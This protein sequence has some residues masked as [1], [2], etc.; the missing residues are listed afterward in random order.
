MDDDAA[1]TYAAA[2]DLFWPGRGLEFLP[3]DIGKHSFKKW[4][5]ELALVAGGPPCQPFSLGGLRA[6][7]TDT[8]DGLP[9]FV[10][11]VR[12]TQPEAFLLENVPGLVRGLMRHHFDQLIMDLEALKYR[13]DWRVLKAADFGVPQRR[14]RLM[15]VGVRGRNRFE[16]PEP[17]HGTPA[18]PHVTAGTLVDAHRIIGAPNLSPVTYA[19]APDLRPSPWDGHVWNGGGRPINPAGLAPTMLASMGGNKTPWLDGGNIV[20]NYHAHLLAGGR[21]RKGAVPGARRITSEEAALLQ[22]F[23]QDMPWR[24][25]RSSRYRQVGNAVPVLLAEQVGK[26]LARHLHAS[27]VTAAA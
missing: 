15:I 4:K 11:V 16:W 24:G 8:R 18:K 5:G 20:E 22:T 14:Q 6:G 10:R 9:E 27:G 26:A 7:E 25:A 2:H 21:A 19:K 23:P 1:E 13:V 17:T 3:G 12:E